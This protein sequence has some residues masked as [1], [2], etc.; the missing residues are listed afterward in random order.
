MPAF[1]HP[2]AYA[3]CRSC[4][5]STTVDAADSRCPACDG[6]SPELAA[7]VGRP[8]SFFIVHDSGREHAPGNLAGA[9]IFYAMTHAERTLPE[10]RELIARRTAELPRIR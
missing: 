4:G 8:A 3:L 1:E 10:T 9:V 7:I 2:N 6:I 5:F